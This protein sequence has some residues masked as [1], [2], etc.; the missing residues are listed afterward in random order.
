MVRSLAAGANCAAC[1]SR[2]RCRSIATLLLSHTTAASSRITTIDSVAEIMRC[3]TGF[4]LSQVNVCTPQA[5]SSSS[6]AAKVM[7]VEMP[8]RSAR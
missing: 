3:P 1:V 6:A 8:C 2:S 5:C 7:T 4:A